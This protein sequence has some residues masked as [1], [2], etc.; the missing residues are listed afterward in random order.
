MKT[1]TAF[2]AATALAVSAQAYAAEGFIVAD[3][4]LQSGPDDEYPPVD[5]LAAGT[6]VNIEGCLEGWTWCDVDVGDLRGWVPG[7]YIEQSYGGR[8]VY[9]TDHGPRIGL[10]IVVF[11]LNTYWGAHYSSRPW[12]GERERWASRQIR[13]RMPARPQGEAHAPPQRAMQQTTRPMQVAPQRQTQQTTPPENSQ[14]RA[15]ALQANPNVAPRAETRPTDRE[16]PHETRSPQPQNNNVAPPPRPERER[17][18]PAKPTTEP[19]NHPQQTQPKSANPERPRT[20]SKPKPEPKQ[21]VKKD[22]QDHR[23]ENNGHD[24]EI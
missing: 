3:I 11:S 1:L 15:P 22:N 13:P 10:P 5:Q 20:E 7:T 24:A 21:P 19:A 17:A 23:D 9:I 4:T 18:G 6:P 12:F 8:W 16:R 14:H 2:F